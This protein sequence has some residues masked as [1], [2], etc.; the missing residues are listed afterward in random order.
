M[1][2]GQYPSAAFLWVAVSKGGFCLIRLCAAVVS[3]RARISRSWRRVGRLL[4]RSCNHLAGAHRLCSQFS[5]TLDHRREDVRG[6]A[7]VSQGDDF[8]RA[9]VV[10]DSGVSDA[11]LYDRCINFR[12]RHLQDVRHASGVSYGRGP[13]LNRSRARARCADCRTWE[14]GAEDQRAPGYTHP[15]YQSNPNGPEWF[16]DFHN[17]CEVGSAR[18][19][20]FGSPGAIG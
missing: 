11:G 16:P 18:E 17:I 10:G 9:Q 14:W 12:V 3:R 6:D 8:A 19:K 20:A 4:R 2:V 13:R 1:A 15:A 5:T 7:M